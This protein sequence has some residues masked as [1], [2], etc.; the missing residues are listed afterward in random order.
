[1]LHNIQTVINQNKTLKE[2]E[3]YKLPVFYKFPFHLFKKETWDVEHIDSHTENTLVDENDQKEWLI[4]SYDFVEDTIKEE[5]R[6]FL[7]PKE[8]EEKPNFS[9]ITGKSEDGTSDDATSDDK[10]DGKIDEKDKLWNFCL[11]DSSTNRSYKN[12]IFPAKRR[13]LTGK[14]QG[15]KITIGI[16][17][18]FNVEKEEDETNRFLK[19]EEEEG[20]AIAFIP[21]CTRNVFIK[22]NNPKPTDFMSWNKQDAEMYLKNIETTLEKFLK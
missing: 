21:P 15:K 2:S 20:R 4:Y 14:D 11:L 1:L 18:S 12:A 6:R 17:D 8:G 7:N 9:E 3:K 19:V 22:Y 10:L 16:N 13:I 5:I